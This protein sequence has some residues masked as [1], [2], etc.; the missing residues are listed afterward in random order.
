M[1]RPDAF[2]I[3]KNDPLGLNVYFGKLVD[4]GNPL[5]AW[6][7][8]EVCIKHDQEFPHWLRRYLL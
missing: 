3:W 2:E 8:I 1:L 5:Y 6:M 4:S 7:A